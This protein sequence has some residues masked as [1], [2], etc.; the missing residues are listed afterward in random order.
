MTAI[1]SVRRS[2]ILEIESAMLS[3]L[4]VLPAARTL[5]RGFLSNLYQKADE[6][7]RKQAEVTTREL[8]SPPADVKRAVDTMLA[9]LGTGDPVK[10]LQVFRSERAACSGCH[11]MGYIGKEIGPDLTHIGGSRT[12]EALLEAIL[13]PSAR[14]EQS[15]QSTQILTTDGQTYN[16]LLRP[17]SGD[18]LELILNAERKVTIPR[19]EIDEMQASN[20]SVMPQGIE[21]LLT[22]QDL[23][24]LLAL[25]RSAQ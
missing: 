19:D 4:R 7:L 21:Q 11:R 14:L 18:S 5:P 17:S 20:L 3:Q 6:S 15:Y 8:E 13:Y 23:A 10:G 9:K 22:P 16:G 24:D 25:L 1:E 12:P 2:G